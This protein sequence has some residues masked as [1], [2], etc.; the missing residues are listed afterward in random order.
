MPSANWRFA[1]QSYVDFNVSIAAPMAVHNESDIFSLL[2]HLLFLPIA[3]NVKAMVGMRLLTSQSSLRFARLV[4]WL[5][6]MRLE[7]QY[8]ICKYKYEASDT[9]SGGDKSALQV[10]PAA[11]SQALKALN[12]HLHARQVLRVCQ[13]EPDRAGTGWAGPG[14]AG[15]DRAGPGWAG[16]GWAAILYLHA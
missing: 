13:A 10:G 11:A 12:C 16:T 6:K 1:R 5:P 3:E 14:R 2:V 8:T 7:T 4:T 15:S 9:R